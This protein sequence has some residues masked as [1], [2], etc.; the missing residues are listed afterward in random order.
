M[1]YLLGQVDARTLLQSAA[2]DDEAVEAARLC[3]AYALIGEVS[4]LGGNAEQAAAA[5]RACLDTDVQ[6]ALA[7]RA[8]TD[9]LAR[10]EEAIRVTQV[11]GTPRIGD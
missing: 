11:G 7:F 3:N 10:I 9:Q 4:L 1:R 5:F 2:N 6:S 8:A